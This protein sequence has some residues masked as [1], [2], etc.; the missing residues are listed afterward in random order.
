MQIDKPPDAVPPNW[1]LRSR[2]TAPRH[3]ER[4]IP[5]SRLLEMLSRIPA[6]H[7]VSA[8]APP[9]FG[10]SV[11]LL[12]WHAAIRASGRP[13]A[14]L[15]VDS[16]D[17]P[18][19]VVQFLAFACHHAGLDVARTGLLDSSTLTLPSPLA[20]QAL[21]GSIEHSGNHW[22]LVIDDADRASKAVVHEVFGPLAR[23]LPANLTVAFAA[24]DPGIQDLSDLEQ[25]GL[26]SRIDSEAL[27]F[28]R[29]EVWKARF[30]GAPRHVEFEE[31]GK[32]VRLPGVPVTEHTSFG[33]FPTVARL[34]SLHLA[35][36][37]DVAV[38]NG[39]ALRWQHRGDGDCL[40]GE[41]GEFHL[42]RCGIAMDV[43][44]R[45]DIPRQQTLAGEVARQHNAVVF[46]DQDSSE[47]YAVISR[48]AEDPSVI[49]PRLIHP[50]SEF[51][52]TWPDR[53]V[54]L[55]PGMCRT[56]IWCARIV[57]WCAWEGVGKTLQV[58]DL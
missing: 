9:G 36:M 53:P 32:G 14:W 13:A 27:R 28:T 41:G 19:V 39:P 30:S 35:H 52:E 3:L 10:K 5:R 7:I 17:G 15:T 48:G 47:G 38:A 4:L 54:R 42:V 55:V 20:L 2:V 49:G 45:S 25:R 16:A 8:C 29:E 50:R 46:F 31:V 34:G 22:H 18:G 23:F 40:S 24:R 1:L 56:Q 11:L 51:D 21:L 33:R 26:V 12:A 44:N 58:I 57:P 6:G 37:V 43:D